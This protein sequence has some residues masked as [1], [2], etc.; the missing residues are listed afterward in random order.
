MICAFH[1]YQLRSTNTYTRAGFCA[2]VIVKDVTVVSAWRL[3]LGSAFI[4]S[5]ILG[6]GIFFC[7]E[8]PRYAPIIVHSHLYFVD[9]TLTDATPDGS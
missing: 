6:A 7:P 8:S 9:Q 4:P 1:I 2:N 5:F 3:Q